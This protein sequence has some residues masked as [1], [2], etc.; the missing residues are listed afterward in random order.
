M[1]DFARVKQACNLQ[2]II[3]RETCLQI[4]KKHLEKC[5]FC[6][7]HE[8]FS[9]NPQ[10]GFYKCFQCDKKGDVF[11]FLMEY[12][13][14]D[15]KDALRKAAS[16]AGIE[17]EKNTHGKKM[18]GREKLF[19]EAAA[20]YHK[21]LSLNG[22]GAYFT[23]ERGHSPD[24]VNKM[25]LGF[26]DGK[27]WEHLKEAGHTF[28]EMVE[29]GLV[30]A[31]SEGGFYDFFRK[32][33]AVFPHFLAGRVVHFTMK[34]PEK[35]LSPYQLPSDK[36]HK[37]WRFYN[38]DALRYDELFV[39]EGENDLLSILD[40]GIYGVI[41]TS[42]Q[43]QDIQINALKNNKRKRVFLWMDN[44]EDPEKPYAKGKG[45]IRKICAALP[46]V[47]FLIIVYPEKAKDPDEH[48]QQ[49][50]TL[51]DKRREVERLKS[52]AVD[53]LAWEIL[54][55]GKHPDMEKKLAHLAKFKVFHAVSLESEIR[56]QVYI[57]KL[58]ALGFSRKSI[59]DQ[60]ETETDIRRKLSLYSESLLKKADA[61]PVLISDMLFQHFK[62]R[63]RFFRTKKEEVFLLYKNRTYEI[64]NNLPFNS[65]MMRTTDM[66]PTKEPGRSV[67]CALANRGYSY[68]VEI[69]AANWL[70]TDLQTDTVFVSLNSQEN[71]ILKIG[72]KHVEEI[73]NGMNN[74]NVLLKT[75]ASI[76]PFSYI[77][78]ASM[79]EGFKALRELLFDNLACEIEQRYLILAWMI[80][81]FLFDFSNMQALMKFSGSRASGKTTGARLISIIFYGIEDVGSQSSASA[82]AEASRN[83]VLFIDNLEQKNINISM[84]DFLLLAASKSSKTKR[85]AGTDSETIKER[86]KSLVLTTAIEPFTLSELISRTCEIG[87]H[88]RFHSEFFMDS[89]VTRKLK[90]KR[91]LILS[92]LIKFVAY[93]VLPGLEDRK[94]YM[95]ILKREYKDHAQERNNEYLAL[96]MVILNSILKYIPYY[97]KSSVLYGVESGESEIRKRWIEYQNERSRDLETGSND[98][99][100]MFNGIVKDYIYAMKNR[101]VE[102][103]FDVNRMKKVF[104]YTHQDYGLE[105]VKTIPE[106][107]F[108][109]ETKDFLS[110]VEIEF[111]A[112]A[113]EIVYAFDAYCKNK[114][115]KNPYASAVVFGRRLEN[116]IRVLKTQNWDIVSNEGIYPYFKI[117]RGR[118][119]YKFV[120]TLV[121]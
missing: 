41:G 49:F 5:P 55:A 105:I 47:P 16:M 57:E 61:D 56:Q 94:N 81:A 112:T 32:G 58:E 33:T 37:A 69:Q 27:L 68:G 66:L 42:G 83:P 54:Q 22:G 1:D 8:C 31:G 4:K 77:P 76:E 120:N 116:D 97:K 104:K 90:Q 17:L 9:I 88:E 50:K 78:D 40:A 114:G 89:E 113:G 93:H 65:L 62:S 108:D 111:M 18:S 71:T 60:L 10:D 14:M 86:P 46:G 102:E 28:E 107:F 100:K 101:D 6:K 45:Y 23:R 15:I 110:K 36:K 91:D 106:G 87:F 75:S 92:C 103:I 67:W 24:V 11:T 72:R 21:C 74:D 115:L 59:E 44:D 85:A 12:H 35:K 13:G 118:R 84:N 34:D 26:S 2:D 30:K 25:M 39:V 63:G 7:G 38:Q 53:Y 52:G 121:K 95:M 96:L 80:S 98:I 3:C 73:P 19:L 79:E 48:L 70:Y 117:T 43:V 29:S 109:E 82:F 99:L 51:Q 119:Y 64:N 20:H